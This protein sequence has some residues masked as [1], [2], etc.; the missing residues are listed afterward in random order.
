MGNDFLGITIHSETILDTAKKA[1]Y[2]VTER[3]KVGI[4]I[5]P[6]GYKFRVINKPSEGDPINFSIHLLICKL[7]LID[8]GQ[9]VD[10]GTAF[11]RIAF[12]CPGT[13][14]PQ[15]EENVKSENQ[16][17]IKPLVSLDTPGKAAVQVVI[18]ADPDGHEI[19]YVGDEGFR[20]SV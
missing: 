6:D 4:L 18:L 9:I 7:E 16:T 15:L 3:D 13:E 8:I 17:I 1:G 10:H 2:P 20:I 12:S 11:G 5:S 19:C 14:L